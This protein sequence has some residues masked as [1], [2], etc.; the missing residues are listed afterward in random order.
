MFVLSILNCDRVRVIVI[1]F[2]HFHT[3]PL[4]LVRTVS[5]YFIVKGIGPSKTATV[6]LD[7]TTWI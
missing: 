7:R 1:Y 6:F 4:I 5:R 2:G 3:F